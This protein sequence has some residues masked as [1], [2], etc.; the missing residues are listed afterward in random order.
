MTTPT[1]GAIRWDAWYPTVSTDYGYSEALTFGDLDLHPYS[2]VHWTFPNSY[3]VTPQPG[4]QAIIDNEITVGAANGVNYWAYLMYNTSPGPNYAAG[5]MNAWNFH[6]S[7]SIKAAMP[8]V[9]MTQ[10][11]LMGSTGSYTANVDTLVSYFQQTNYFTVLAGR[12]LL[13][14]YWDTA[15]FATYWG[16]TLANV[17]AMITALRAACTT[18]SVANPYIVV[19]Y[20]I[21]TTIYTGIGADAISSYI[22]QVSLTPLMTY[23]GYDTVVRAYW[24]SMLASGA[25]MVPNASSG[26]TD[27]GRKRRPVPYQV[28]TQRPRIGLSGTVARPTIAELKAHIAAAQA[29]VVAN[30]APCASNTILLYSWNEHS[31]GVGIGPEIGTPSGLAL[32]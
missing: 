19:V 27:I 17:A 13:Y 29:F 31:E 14:I 12:P 3:T 16:S 2:P 26:F 6:Q 15:A 10:L 9:A 23:A 28:T 7:S 32:V 24:A 30:P 1:I 18:A 8:W 21:N 22:P 4:A 20:N 25:P 11:G 5:L